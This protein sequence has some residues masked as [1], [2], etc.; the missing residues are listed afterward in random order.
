[1]VL[2][3][4]ELAPG[5]LWLVLPTPPTLSPPTLH[6]AA[7]LQGGGPGSCSSLP[8]LLT[9]P[10]LPPPSRSCHHSSRPRG[11]EAALIAPCPQ[12]ARQS[13]C[14]CPPK[15]VNF[16][17]D[18]VDCFPSS[19]P[20]QPCPVPQ[21]HSKASRLDSGA[22]SLGPPGPAGRPPWG[23]SKARP[24]VQICFRSPTS[25]TRGV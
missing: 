18:S 5:A 2:I 16:K 13:C 1:M 22:F 23:L 21:P 4:P 9:A 25:K 20:L 11:E 12:V 15:T 6:L 10:S 17:P 7:I 24:P 19:L 8:P 3:R 14:C